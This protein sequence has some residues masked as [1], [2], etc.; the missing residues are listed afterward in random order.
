M[1]KNT[2]VFGIF[3]NR[4]RLETSIDTLRN[5]GFRAI[6]ISVLLPENYGNKDMA[7]AKSN[8]G[9][10]GAAAGAASGAV[11]GGALGWL[12]GIG[13]LTI[14]GAGPFIGAGPIMAAMAGVGAGATL[15]G[16]TGALAGMGMPEFEA[17]R[18]AGRVKSGGI[19]LSIHCDDSDWV[20]KAKRILT[21]T[22]A[23]DISSTA[24]AMADYGATDKPVPRYAQPPAH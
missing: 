13:L 18:Y 17:K 15:G 9:P 8:K 7:F 5:G 24:E 1:S 3:Q 21:D 10:E 23:E 11:L 16:L 6:D 2:A 19:L 12:V 20:R 14:P 4:E 22:G